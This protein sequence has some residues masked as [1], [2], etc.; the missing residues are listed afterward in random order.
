MEKSADMSFKGNETGV[1]CMVAQRITCR[2]TAA[3]MELCCTLNE[4]IFIFKEKIGEKT[5]SQRGYTFHKSRDNNQKSQEKKS[6][7]LRDFSLGN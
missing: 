4:D 1:S 6:R 7:K 2:A 5:F 3:K